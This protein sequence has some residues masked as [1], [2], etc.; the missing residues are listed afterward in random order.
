M[1]CGLGLSNEEGDISENAHYSVKAK[2][3]WRESHH[4]ILFGFYVIFH[5]VR[6]QTVKLFEEH[7]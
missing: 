4:A 3:F 1:R 2:D 7:S 6:L 5:P